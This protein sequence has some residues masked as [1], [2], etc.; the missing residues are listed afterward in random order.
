MLRQTASPLD[1]SDDQR[2]GPQRR[3]AA[4]PQVG[5]PISVKV[6]DEI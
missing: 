6:N 2:L 5:K 1:P 3:A 4:P